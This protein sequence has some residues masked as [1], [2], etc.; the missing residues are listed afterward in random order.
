MNPMIPIV[1]IAITFA[2][3]FFL[4]REGRKMG[5]S[6]HPLA[7]IGIAV[8]VLFFVWMAFHAKQ[9]RGGET[10]VPLEQVRVTK[11]LPLEQAYSLCGLDP[12]MRKN[13]LGL[14][15][16]SEG[17]SEGTIEKSLREIYAQIE[18]A[19]LIEWAVGKIRH[20]KVYSAG[21]FVHEVT[22]RPGMSAVEEALF[23]EL[24]DANGIPRQITLL[25]IILDTYAEKQQE[26]LTMPKAAASVRDEVDRDI[27][28]VKQ[29]LMGGTFNLD[30][31]QWSQLSLDSSFW[32]PD[33]R[34]PATIK[35]VTGPQ[36]ESCKTSLLS[37]TRAHTKLLG[38]DDKVR[39]LTEQETEDIEALITAGITAASSVSDDYLS[40]VDEELPSEFR[41]HLVKGWEMYVAG[42]R[43]SSPDVQKQGIELIQKW[44]SYKE[45][46]KDHLYEAVIK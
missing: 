28:R 25:D 44:Q 41:N 24:L 37:F 4:N 14:A 43:S 17:V 22:L 40:T 29:E 33:I 46:H 15:Q 26:R 7:G 2:I 3:I 9:N 35:R 12:S 31:T 20:L 23:R 5:T 32:G 6:V 16:L 21:P 1:A 36:K 27:A 18:P 42:L 10:D 39:R 45:K 38:E 8:V 11:L 19:G 30:F 34:A 13:I